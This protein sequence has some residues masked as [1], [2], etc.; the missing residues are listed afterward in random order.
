MNV[1]DWM[2][3]NKTYIRNITIS[4]A[5]IA[6]ITWTFNTYFVNK[7]KPQEKEVASP[8]KTGSQPQEPSTEVPAQ[9]RDIQDWQYQLTGNHYNDFDRPAQA[10][11]QYKENGK[12]VEMKAS[13]NPSCHTVTLMRKVTGEG[14]SS[15]WELTDILTN[16]VSKDPSYDFGIESLTSTL[17]NS[18]DT[19]RKSHKNGIPMNDLERSASFIYGEINKYFTNSNSGFNRKRNQIRTD[20]YNRPRDNLP[21]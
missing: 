18:A 14:R 19:D 10:H 6:G 4:I 8:Q 12:I 7:P 1:P 20:V 15:A 16:N 13:Y 9:V 3:N 21:R 11:F 17:P 5:A 2:S